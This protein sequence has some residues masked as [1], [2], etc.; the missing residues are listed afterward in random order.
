[1][2]MTKRIFQEQ[3]STVDLDARPD[4]KPVYP[5]GCKQDAATR[6]N[7]LIGSDR[8]KGNLAGSL[9]SCKVGSIR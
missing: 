9:G 1:M 8:V 4:R 2:H 3:L 7:N 5:D 6:T